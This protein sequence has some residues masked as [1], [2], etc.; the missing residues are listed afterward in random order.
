MNL[1]LAY[2][3]AFEIFVFFLCS[4]RGELFVD[5][6]GDTIE[7]SLEPAKHVSPTSVATTLERGAM[8]VWIIDSMVDA[9]ETCL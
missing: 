6:V 3:W 2:S 9:I 5:H 8:D 4:P 1:L 7:A